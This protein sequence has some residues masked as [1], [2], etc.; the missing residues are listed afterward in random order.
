MKFQG[1]LF[2]L[3]GTLIDSRADIA[4]S[5]NLTLRDLGFITLPEPRVIEFV[6]EGVRL[7]VERALRASLE[8]M[9]EEE[10]IERALPIYAGHYRAHLL[11]QT[12]LY[13]GVR[14]TL[15]ALASFP[16]AVVTNKPIAF[17]KII[18]Q[19]LNLE[20]NFR[21]VLGGDSTPERKPAP[22]PLLEAARQCAVTAAH[23]LMVGDTKIDMEAG[24]AAG[25][26]TCGFIGGFR[27]AGELRNANA[28]FLIEKIPDLLTLI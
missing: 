15:A 14:E 17:T 4:T 18:L 11:D 19:E 8:R 1:L 16:K 26:K 13:E 10:L 2:D 12:H 7:L 5:L 27:G 20:N 3:D 6:G 24:K 28:D 23:C 9:P 21:A 25:M 22:L